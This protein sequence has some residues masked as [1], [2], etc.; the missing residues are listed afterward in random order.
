MKQL[1]DNT[2]TGENSAISDEKNNADRTAIVLSHICRP[3][4]VFRFFHR[5][6]FDVKTDIEYPNRFRPDANPGYPTSYPP[7]SQP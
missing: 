4:D 1:Q 5:A 2:R 6:E 3:Y 7:P